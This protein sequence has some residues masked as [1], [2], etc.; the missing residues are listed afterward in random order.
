MCEDVPD[1]AQNSSAPCL[2]ASPCWYFRGCYRATESFGVGA[3]LCPAL[4]APRRQLSYKRADSSAS[5]TGGVESGGT[6]DVVSVQ[7]LVR[8]W[9]GGGRAVV[10]VPQAISAERGG[11]A[12]SSVVRELCFRSRNMQFSG[13]CAQFSHEVVRKGV[14]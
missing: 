10:G 13:L 1:S 8:T 7:Q 6:M 12:G 2:A 11:Q 9:V 5:L 4:P 3:S 14:R